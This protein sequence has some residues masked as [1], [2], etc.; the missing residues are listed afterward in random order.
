MF[1]CVMDCQ[2]NS[3]LLSESCTSSSS[4]LYLYTLLKPLVVLSKLVE[5]KV[6]LLAVAVRGCEW[7]R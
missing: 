6:R 2:G 5:K 1:D 4:S 7:L 3:E